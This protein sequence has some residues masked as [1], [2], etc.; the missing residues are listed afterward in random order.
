MTDQ[1]ELIAESI[2]TFEE[3]RKGKSH[4]II[5][6][7]LGVEDS[8]LLEDY[9]KANNLTVTDALKHLIRILKPQQPQTPSEGAQGRA[10]C[11]RCWS[12]DDAT[13]L[14]ERLSKVAKEEEGSIYDLVD[15]LLFFHKED[16]RGE[17]NEQYDKAHAAVVEQMQA[18]AAK[19]E[20]E[21][22]EMTNFDKEFENFDEEF[23][24]AWAED[25][26]I[27]NDIHR[28][29][30]L[31]PKV[32]PVELEKLAAQL[33]DQ[34]V[35]PNLPDPLAA[36]ATQ[37][38][39]IAQRLDQLEVG[40]QPLQKEDIRPWLEAIAAEGG[41]EAMLEQLAAIALAQNK[42]TPFEAL[43]F[44]IEF[45]CCFN[46]L[47]QDGAFTAE[48]KQ[49]IKDQSGWVEPTQ[50]IAEQL[51]ALAAKVNELEERLNVQ[52]GASV[53]RLQ[54]AIDDKIRRIAMEHP[55]ERG[56]MNRYR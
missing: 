30:G 55:R 40:S 3:F 2:R 9:A 11:F 31:K 51:G 21:I 43:T 14:Y 16:R 15:S 13:D 7:G 29:V 41:V 4:H 22:L 49:F 25:E 18:T 34:P 19:T 54:Q 36:I 28:K 35:S 5:T 8:R 20:D 50:A 46:R 45:Y 52:E 27:I 37:L 48:A 33:R 26:Q 38:Q 23:G 10:V 32:N 44:L 17:L 39:A 47:L 1:N 42:T 12:N 53:E 6:L 56:G 24:D